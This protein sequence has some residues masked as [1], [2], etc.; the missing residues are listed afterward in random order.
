[1]KLLFVTLFLLVSVPFPLL[2][3]GKSAAENEYVKCEIVLQ[4]KE[5]KAGSSGYVLISFQPKKGIHITTDPPF[6]ISLDTSRQVFTLGKAEFS[7]DDNGYLNSR[8]G[9][10]QPLTVAGTAA[11]GSYAMRGTLIYYYCSENDG[12]CSRFKQPIDLTF[13]VTK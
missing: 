8:K 12:W 3:G 2:G 11:P 4:Q 1:M 10:R 7:R 5:L 6:R 9:V 13:T